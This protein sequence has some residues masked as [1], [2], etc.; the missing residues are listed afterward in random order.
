MFRYVLLFTVMGF[1]VN[2]SLA[3]DREYSEAEISLL[4]VFEDNEKLN[5]ATSASQCTTK[6]EQEVTYEVKPLKKDDYLEQHPK[7]DVSKLSHIELVDLIEN[8]GVSPNRYI[9]I[10][11]YNGYREYRHIMCCIKGKTNA[12]TDDYGH[13]KTEDTLSISVQYLIDKGALLNCPFK[14]AVEKD[15]EDC[16]SQRTCEQLLNPQAI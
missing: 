10:F 15:K 5:H 11:H 2:N 1:S 16:Y 13:Q 14:V 7:V 3:S 6:I 8:K 4:R 9:L 12:W